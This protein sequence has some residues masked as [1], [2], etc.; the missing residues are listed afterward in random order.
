M[1]CIWKYYFWWENVCALLQNSED[2]SA[3]H[4]VIQIHVGHLLYKSG[5]FICGFKNF[6]EVAYWF[7]FGPTV[8][9]VKFDCVWKMKTKPKWIP[10]KK[11]KKKNQKK[12]KPISPW[13][14]E[15][16]YVKQEILFGYFEQFLKFWTV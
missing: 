13:S 4:S 8:G 15:F 16:T 14:S 7:T 11:K 9:I 10:K 1:Q 3:R 6:Y 2:M 12:K 5:I